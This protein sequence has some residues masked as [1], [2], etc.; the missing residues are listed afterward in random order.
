LNGFC[1]RAGES[2]KNVYDDASRV[3]ATVNSLGYYTTMTYN[4]NGQMTC[5]EDANNRR[6]TYSYDALGRQVDVTDANGNITTNVYDAVGQ[7]I[8]MIDPRGNRVTYTYD[9]RGMQ[10]AMTDQ[11]GRIT[12]Y[13]YDVLGRRQTQLDAKGQTI[14]FVYDA[15][16]RMTRKEYSD[17]A[18]ATF[19][20]DAIGNRLT[21]EDGTGITTFSYNS[22]NMLEV[23]TYPGSKTITYSFDEM[24]NRAAMTDPD[25]GITTYS[26]DAANRIAWLLNPFSEYAT[27]TYDSLGQRITQQ[28]G[29]G[30]WVSYTYDDA[31]RLTDQVHLK[32]DNSI[33]DSWSNEHDFV[34]NLIATTETN[35]DIITY[36][37]DSAYQL[38]REQHVSAHP[39]DIT[40]TYDAAGNR[41]TKVDSGTTTTYA[42]DVA[43]QLETEETTSGITTFT[44]DANGNTYVEDA[45][46]DLTTYTW[47]IDNMC[48]GIALPNATLNTFVYDA[49]LKRRQ[50]EDSAGVAKFINDMDNVLLE[51]NSGGTTQAA[52]TLEPQ[53]YGNLLSQRRSGASHFHHFDV[54]G[55]T[56]S[57][58]NAAETKEVHYQ[59]K[60]FGPTEILSGSFAANRYLWNARVGYRWEPDTQQYDIRRR[61]M[62]PG[63]GRFITPDPRQQEENLYVYGQNAPLS[64]VDPSGLSG[65]IIQSG[66]RALASKKQTWPLAVAPHRHVWRQQDWNFRAAVN[67]RIEAGLC[68]TDEPAAQ[69]YHW[70]QWSHFIERCGTILPSLETPGDWEP[71]TIPSN[72]VPIYPDYLVQKPFRVKTKD[73]L[74]PHNFCQFYH[75]WA[76]DGPG[77]AEEP[78]TLSGFDLSYE[79]GWTFKDFVAPGNFF[80]VAFF[81]KAK[82]GIGIRLGDARRQSTRWNIRIT[83]KLKPQKLATITGP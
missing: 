67:V 61:R 43:N 56:D 74:C 46:G 54:I 52:Y 70:Y 40:Y 31:G 69:R 62:R 58:T 22:A 65:C 37:Y 66:P 24:G 10:T 29:N 47:S 19:S 7:R 72:R 75:T 81:L 80:P 42:Y 9:S 13:S 20:Y 28:N 21:M 16:H 53:Q 73:S 78:T 23:V 27:F 32:S 26:Y 1:G 60:A 64:L 55:S 15:A 49:D 50:E 30:T 51:T 34:G 76:F 63:Q 3:I 57:I 77:Y 71:D 59:S 12:T 14:T 5:M 44:F 45:G 39:Y 48:L 36:T 6:T 17:G 83:A 79:G 68:C 11:L 8:A 41:L 35:G 33:F 4:A 25:G 2:D 18:R 82:T 38:T